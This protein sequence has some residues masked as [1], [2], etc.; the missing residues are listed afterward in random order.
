M[1]KILLLT[2]VLFAINEL[3]AQGLKDIEL[4]DYGLTSPLWGKDSIETTLLGCK[5]S[6]KVKKYN[7]KIFDILFTFSN[8]RDFTP[9]MADNMANSLMSKYPNLK[10]ERYSNGEWLD[11]RNSDDIKYVVN[12]IPGYYWGVTYD[13]RYGEHT[14]YVKINDFAIQKKIWDEDKQK[15][16]SDF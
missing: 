3:S 6:L 11:I 7:Y 2:I 13:I 14:A 12:I 4:G 1:R 9:E 16:S 8:N 5:G 10:L 15:K